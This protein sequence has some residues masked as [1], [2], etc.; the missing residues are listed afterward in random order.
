MDRRTSELKEDYFNALIGAITTE[1]LRD[2]GGA[3]LHPAEY[4]MR[5]CEEKGDFSF[6]YSSAPRGNAPGRSWRPLAGPIPALQPWHTFGDGQAGCLRPGHLR[7]DNMCRMTRGPLGPAA[8]QL[9]RFGAR[10]HGG[11]DSAAAPA[12]GLRR[13]RGFPGAGRRILLP[14][15]GGPGRRRCPGV[16]G[17][18]IRWAHGGPG[19]IT[20]QDNGGP[21]RFRDVGVFV[22]PRPAS[23]HSIDLA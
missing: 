13:L 16:C 14:A 11:P 5:L 2:R 1:P 12:G 23:G 22:G 9:R 4:F 19:L 8:D 3:A 21:H 6:I 20:T 7:L 17:G 10:Q 15:D 18:G